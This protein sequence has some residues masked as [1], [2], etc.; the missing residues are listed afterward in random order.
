MSDGEMVEVGHYRW[1]EWDD[2]AGHHAHWQPIHAGDPGA[3]PVFMRAGDVE[4]GQ[5]LWQELH[6]GGRPA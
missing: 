2:H 6:G 1:V 3:V 4:R 5:R